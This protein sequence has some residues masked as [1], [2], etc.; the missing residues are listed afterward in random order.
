MNRRTKIVATL[1]P[2]SSSTD[3]LKELVDA[4]VNVFRLNFSHGNSEEKKELISNIREISKNAEKAV[5]ILGDLQGP[6]IRV[7]ELEGG[8]IELREGQLVIFNTTNVVGAGR[9]IPTT[10]EALTHDVEVGDRILLDDGLMEVQVQHIGNDEVHCKVITGGI[11]KNRK[12]M[13]LPGVK[14]SAPSLTDKDRADLDF[15]IEQGVDYVALSFVRSAEDVKRLKDI[16]KE[17]GSDISVISK[18][19]KPEAVECFDEILKQT[20]G[21]MVARGDLGVEMNAESVPLIQKRIIKKCNCAGKPVITATQMLESMVN[22]AR[23][24]RAETS[25][26]ANAIIDG[27]DAV[28][29]SAE[30]ASGKYPVEA[31]ETMVRIA[32]DVEKDIV[33]A[34]KRSDAPICSDKDLTEAIGNISC[35]LSDSIGAVAILAFTQTGSTAALVAKHRPRVPVI[36]ATPLDKVRR[37]LALYSGVYSFNVESTA[38]TEEQIKAVERQVIDSGIFKKNDLA[39]LTMGSPMSVPGTTNL[40]KAVRLGEADDMTGGE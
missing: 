14:V 30:T 6:K 32:I 20:D 29:L 4:G 33:F 13:N 19:E 24:T 40:V 12:G 22:N 26:V 39:V 15:C 9:L 34:E 1:G 35:C 3:K 36:A 25:D 27:T 38:H 10:Y 37:K 2:A 16:I 31:V 18:I 5:A 11:L 8:E 7:G 21:I 23:P 17:K 28:M